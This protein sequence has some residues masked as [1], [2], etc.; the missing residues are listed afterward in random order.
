MQLPNLQTNPYK[1]APVAVVGD[2]MV[3][4]FIYGAVERISPEAPIPVV[5]VS[6]RTTHLGG[7]GN[8]AYNLK[9]LGAKPLLI[10]RLGD[11]ELGAAFKEIS[12]KA[13]MSTD[14]LVR[15]HL[16]T[17][18]KTRIIARQQQVV[19]FDEEVTDALIQAER[20]AIMAQ[21]KEVRKI[22]SVVI[23]SDYGKGMIDQEMLEGIKEVFKDGTV[24]VDPKPRS[25][26]TYTGVSG[27][28]PNLSEAYGFAGESKGVNTDEAVVKM[29]TKLVEELDMQH[30]LITR[31]ECGMT[32]MQRDGTVTHVDTRAQEIADVSGAGDTVIAA[33]SAGL[34]GG[35]SPI[36]AAGFANVA[37]GI[38][39]G[40]LGTAS[41]TWAE[42]SSEIQQEQKVA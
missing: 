25:T 1:D 8:V 26:I 12:E 2:I 3:D 29:A 9:S 14:Y 6:K 27:M 33:F 16:P 32:L 23:V 10:G 21:L 7:G 36:H 28:T 34:S 30:A 17:I 20:D 4:R 40:K 38:V 39:V 5:Q 35:M 19:R 41:V 13:G 37:A 24:L 11:D 31:S 15:T 42:M 18:S 22:T